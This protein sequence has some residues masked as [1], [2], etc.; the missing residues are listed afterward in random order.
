M[1]TVCW[2]I[3]RYH[4]RYS[5]NW[6]IAIFDKCVWCINQIS[7]YIFGCLISLHGINALWFGVWCTTK[8][9]DYTMDMGFYAGLTIPAKSP[10][11]KVDVDTEP[12]K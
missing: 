10:M 1:S 8:S 5:T 4:E 3:T 11:G 9:N 2:T 6:I 7:I 12:L